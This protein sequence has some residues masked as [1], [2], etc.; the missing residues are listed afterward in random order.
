MH[1]VAQKQPNAFKLYDMV[2]NVWEWVNDYYGEKFYSTSPARDPKG[3]AA[4]DFRILRGGAWFNGPRVARA[5]ARYK[6]APNSRGFSLGF[7][8][9]RDTA[10]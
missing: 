8:C 10:P 2:G 5:T 7:R 6:N 4:G 3:P 9:A 1:P